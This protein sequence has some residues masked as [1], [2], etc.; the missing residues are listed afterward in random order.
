MA[1][2]Y[3]RGIVVN[4]SV[5]SEMAQ[6]AASRPIEVCG[7]LAGTVDGGVTK[8]FAC[9]NQNGSGRTFTIDRAEAETVRNAANDAGLQLLG[10]MHS[11]PYGWPIPSTEDIRHAVR[12]NWIHII[13]GF[14][15][16]TTPRLRAFESA[17]GKL[18]A[19]SII[20]RRSDG[21][22]RE[23]E[24]APICGVKSPSLAPWAVSSRRSADFRP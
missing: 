14:S 8:F 2:R 3:A 18:T 15:V 12:G 9:T 10:G 11:H 23:A 13:I 17:D 16:E 7:L 20:I 5:I 22:L 4:E 21:G 1:M 19:R 6:L 24:C